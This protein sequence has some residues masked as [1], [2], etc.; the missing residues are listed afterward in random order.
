MKTTDLTFTKT[1]C[2]KAYTTNL[3]VD[4]DGMARICCKQKRTFRFPLADEKDRISY[5]KELRSYMKKWKWHP[6]CSECEEVEKWKNISVRQHFNQKILWKKEYTFAPDDYQIVYLEINFSN[7]CN[8][9]CRMCKSTVS[10]WR[11]PLDTHLWIPITR[12]THLGK[13]QLDYIYNLENIHWVRQIEIFWGEP[14]LEKEHFKFLSFLIENDLASQI[15]LGYNSNLTVIPE[16]STKE[17][18]KYVWAKNIF[19]LWAHFKKVDLRISIDG[20]GK[21]DEY[22]RLQSNWSEVIENI[23]RVKSEKPHNLEISVRSTV[24]IDNILDLPNFL[25]YLIHK[26]IDIS[27]SSNNYVIWPDYFC[28]QNLPIPVKKYIHRKM[29]KYLKKFPI[30]EEKYGLYIQDILHFMD[31]KKPIPKEF[32]NYMYISKEI[33]RYYDL[34][35]ENQMTR[36]CK[37]IWII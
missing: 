23:L 15:Q 10:T 6:S 16:F 9:S 29:N 33:D 7:L 14:L 24:Q 35:K 31:A 2:L 30:I 1:T 5:T 21:T 37:K 36:L 26:D 13:P 32:A 3:Y 25:L 20:Y 17:Q 11:I 19:D 8:L 12:H 18:K 34:A 4:A 28:I 27:F 22:I